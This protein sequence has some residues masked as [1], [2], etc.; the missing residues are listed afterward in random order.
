MKFIR[1]VTCSLI[2]LT[3]TTTLTLAKGSAAA[4]IRPS[5]PAAVQITIPQA[6][7]ALSTPQLEDP[8]NP[9]K[10]PADPS[11]GYELTGH[12]IWLLAAALT[13]GLTSALLCWFL[14]RTIFGPP[15]K[16]A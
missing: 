11:P 1:L 12:S 14:Q 3:L 15:R 16:P 2:L 7:G 6:T 5:L 8:L 4:I 9:A 10:A 13:V